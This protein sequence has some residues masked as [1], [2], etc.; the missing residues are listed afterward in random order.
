[1]KLSRVYV[2]DKCDYKTTDKPMP[3]ICIKEQHY[4]HVEFRL[5]NNLVTYVNCTGTLEP[6]LSQTSLEGMIEERIKEVNKIYD[7]CDMRIG[8]LA[9]LQSILN[10][11]RE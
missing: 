5:N 2:C 3:Q 9:E 10:A 7:D 1:M 11:V 6:Y 8:Q 4:S